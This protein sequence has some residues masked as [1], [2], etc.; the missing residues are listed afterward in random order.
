[1]RRLFLFGYI[2]WVK[3]RLC[4]IFLLCGVM[5]VLGQK[6]DRIW[7]F[8]SNAG[9]DFN[10]TLNPIPFS[11]NLPQN[12]AG[13]YASIADTNGNLL[14]YTAGIRWDTL[15]A[16]IYNRNFQMM[17]N[18]DSIRGQPGRAQALIIIPFPEDISKYYLFSF[19][20]I[21]YQIALHYSVIDMQQDSGLGA[22]VQKNVFLLRDTLCEKMNAVRHAN[23][24]DWWLLQRRYWNNTYYKFL[25]TPSGVYGPV[26]QSIGTMSGTFY[27]EMEFTKSGNRLV[28]VSTEGCIDLMDFDRCTGMLSNYV[29]IGEHGSW[30][31]STSYYGCAFSPD[32]TKLYVT[33]ATNSNDIKRIYQY[34]LTAGNIM[35]SKFV[36][37]SYADSLIFWLGEMQLAPDGRIYVGKGNVYNSYANTVYDQNIDYITN[38][39]N[40]GIAC[41]YCSNCFNLQGYGLSELGLPNMPN[42]NLGA[43]TGSPCDS[44]TSLEKIS[45]VNSYLSI[46]PNPTSST[47]TITFTY[48]SISEA[49]QIVINDINGKEM[50]RYALPQWSSVHKVKLPEM[51]R[52]VYVAR[53]LIPNSQFPIPN[54]KF[55]VN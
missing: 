15:G 48:P 32:E 14:F 35:A 23:G 4:L 3:A 19:S 41:N 6:Q 21:S 25:I 37:Q 12:A 40:P 18:G 16:R 26:T 50:V 7:C 28:F 39:N 49:K 10:D 52:G 13:S 54:V 47:S 9:I 34:D 17:Q 46:Y 43:L 2:W 5:G 1:M 8:G 29:D 20:Y 33:T 53:L 42:Y 27:G 24:R 22:V 51:S 30:D 11:S 31:P 36:V 45:T 55:V 38:P 44:I